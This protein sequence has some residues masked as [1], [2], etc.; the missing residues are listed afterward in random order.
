MA[1]IRKGLA[2]SFVERYTLIALS[3]V[4]YVL[5]ARLLTPSEIG[6]YSVTA[7]LIGIAQVIRDFGVGNYIIQERDLDRDR[8]E[9]A[10]GV[11]LIAGVATC[12]IMN[13][14]A[15]LIA[16]FYSEAKM[17]GVIQILS[18]NI[19]ILPFSTIAL[20]MHRRLMR[21][22]VILLANL[23]GGV[24]GVATTIFFATIKLGAVSLA[25]GIVA[26]NLT[27]SVCA[28]VKLPEAARPR[29]PRLVQWR[30]IFAYGRQSTTAGAAVAVA[31]DIN[32]TVVGKLLGF[33]P[34]AILSRGM[35]IMYLF[36]RDLLGA[37]RNVALPA[38]AAA[39]RG[40]NALEPMFV[41]TFSCVTAV[42]WSFYGFLML[43]PLEATRLLAG[44]QWDEAV[45]YVVLFS[46][47]GALLC[48]APLTQTVLTAA[49]KVAMAARADL[50]TSLL[51]LVLVSVAAVVFRSLPAVAWAMFTSLVV[52]MPI[53]MAF[54]H[55]VLPNDWSALAAQSWKG[56]LV[57]GGTLLVPAI[58]SIVA[59][60]GR[61]QPMSM[62][63]FAS[64]AGAT[65]LT[66]P[67]M[68]RWCRHPLA[69]DP[70]YLGVTQRIL[71]WVKV[72][73]AA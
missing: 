39:N 7:A 18:I 62:G 21:F 58:V 2:W 8:L 52:S 31:M 63:L 13:G 56:L 22:D 60:L 33:T 4:S 6:L 65:A 29:R 55:R 42:G 69:S 28:W 14:C 12:T 40:G 43:Y 67:L 51:R 59:G 47:A 24:V 19:L 71:G 3:L 16:R 15:P 45:P 30:V 35:G 9:T 70:I 64:M 27:T 36:Q 23:L 68:L 53:F 32:D 44:T 11:S 20:G 61:T 46:V 73:R 34:A 10:Y 48:L 50:V 66:W 17:V 25:G 5:I 37:A 38:F 54:K 41:Y 26:C 72:L 49:G 57:T 1:S